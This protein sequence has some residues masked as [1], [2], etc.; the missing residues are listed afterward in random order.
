MNKDNFK[1]KIKLLKREEKYKGTIL[2]MYEDT[3]EVD[4]NICHWDYLDNSSAAAILP[5]MPDGKIL[6]VRQYRLAVDDYTLEIPAGKL[7][8]KNEDFLVCAK[9]ELEEETGYKSDDFELL[10]TMCSSV[11]FWDLRVK[12]FLAK[13]LKKGNIHFDRDE[14]TLIETY[15]INELKKMVFDGTIYDAKTCAGI[16]AYLVKINN[17]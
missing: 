13:N 9:R 3:V 12:I 17:I 11:T 15:D 14:E 10:L 2:T 8:D 7:D 6:L 4:G 1:K 5:V 16:M